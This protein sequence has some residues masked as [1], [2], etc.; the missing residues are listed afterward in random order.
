MHVHAPH[1]GDG[2]QRF[3]DAALR[4]LGGQTARGLHLALA[5]IHGVR[6]RFHQSRFG[7]GDRFAHVGDAALVGHQ[8]FGE[9]SASVEDVLHVHR[10]T[11]MAMPRMPNLLRRAR[12]VPSGSSSASMIS[13]SP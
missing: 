10:N 8:R 2:T 1:G 11:P 3:D 6:S 4:V 5:L 12:F 7:V 13:E 9:L